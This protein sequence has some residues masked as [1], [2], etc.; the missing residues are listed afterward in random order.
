MITAAASIRASAPAGILLTQFRVWAQG[1]GGRGA[2]AAAPSG[3]AA[4]D[5]E[6]RSYANDLASTR[7]SPL[8]QINASNFNKL[9]VAWQFRTDNLGSGPEVNNQCTPLLAKGRLFCTAG[10]RRDVMA[11]DAATGEQLWLYRH[12]EGQRRGPRT[13]S[14]HGASYWTDGTNERIFYITPGYQL[15]SLDAKTGI[16]DAA[17]GKNGIVDLRLDDDQ[18]IDLLNG[19]IGLHSTPLVA[20]N[21][22]VVGAAHLDGRIPLVRNNVK[23]YTR[24]FDVKS[25]KRLWIFHTIPRKGEFG[26][27]TWTTEGQAEMTGNAGVWAQM[28]AD[29]ELGLVYIGVEMPTGDYVGIYRQGSGLFGES[30]VALDLQTGLR[31]W[32]FQMVHHGLWDRDC[33]CASVLCDIPVNGRIVKAIAQP[34]KQTFLYVLNRETGEPIWPIVEKPV[35]KGDVAGEWYSPTQP[36]PTKPPAYDL[37]D[38]ANDVLVDFTPAIKARAV[39]IASHYK[40]GPLFTPPVVTEPKGLWGTL[41]LPGLTGGSNWPG[42][43]YDPETHTIHLYSKTTISVAGVGPNANKESD[44]EVVGT[45]VGGGGGRG[46]RGGTA[47]P[48]SLDGPVDFGTTTVAGLPLTKPPYGRIT[49]IDLSKGDIVWQIAHGETPD[50]IRNHPLLKGL[51]IPRTGS[52]GVIGTLTTKACVICGDA[53]AFTDNTGR[54]GAGLRAYDKATGTEKG[55]VFMPG[56]QTGAPMTYMLGGRQYIVLS[57]SPVGGGAEFIAFRLPG[58]A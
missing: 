6:W 26:Y 8:D 48:V 52:S 7:Y 11:V 31:K 36:I 38:V 21:V 41:V 1:R 19:D 53:V 12:D 43:S 15:I 30:I 20:K 28:S 34:T 46:G 4:T 25:G 35:P 58:N 37:Q 56:Q 14:G 33:P 18:Q 42:A 47:V 16:P 27:E 45:Q 23:G 5:T 54:Q 40:M 50:A 2:A 29:E 10:A 57:I 9:E 32:H 44:F 55:A 22:V 49:A 51:N 13:G 24:G 39:E 3:P 17:F